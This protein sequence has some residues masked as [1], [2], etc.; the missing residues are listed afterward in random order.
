MATI[1]LA[2]VKGGVSKTSLAL[3]LASELALDGYRVALLDADLNQQAAA[4]GRKS[5][6]ANLTIVGDAREDNILALLRQAEA[7][8]EVVMVDLPGGSSTLALKSLHRSHFVI[9]PTQPSLPD[10]MAAMK[11]IAQIDDAQELARTPIARAIV[12]TRVLPGFESRAA[13]HVRQ[14][15]EVEQGV[16]IL[17]TA[18]MERAAFRE[19]HITGKVPRQTDPNGSAAANVSALAAELLQEIAKL[20]EAA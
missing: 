14:T 7:D 5:D 16:P 11:T 6:I 18:L 10:V 17:K 9:V 20:R 1:S 19:L 2:S 3:L 8:N 4:F 13:R 15:V 12:W